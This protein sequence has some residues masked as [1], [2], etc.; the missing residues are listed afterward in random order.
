MIGSP[1]EAL[2]FNRGADGELLYPSDLERLM[3]RRECVELLVTTESELANLDCIS[4]K[5]LRG[6]QLRSC[7][8]LYCGDIR[9]TQ[10]AGFRHR[11][12][13]NP[14]APRRFPPADPLPLAARRTS[15]P[16]F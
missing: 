11:S 16:I 9:G 14:E 7:G 13:I 8:R 1:V 15:A 6:I 2:D 10:A 5:R 3:L 4:P 12:W